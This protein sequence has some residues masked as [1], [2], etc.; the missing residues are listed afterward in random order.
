LATV[1]SGVDGKPPHPITGKEPKSFRFD[2]EE[3]CI[4]VMN[5]AK[6]TDKIGFWL[7]VNPALAKHDWVFAWM[8]SV[9]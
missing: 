4:A 8:S 9:S 2:N 7:S 1:P 6:K 5:G 3:R